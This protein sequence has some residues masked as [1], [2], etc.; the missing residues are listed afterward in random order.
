MHSVAESS[1]R[2]ASASS[3]GTRTGLTDLEQS[4]EVANNEHVEGENRRYLEASTSAEKR[5]HVTFREGTR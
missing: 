5:S 4:R 1:M 2:F 3:H